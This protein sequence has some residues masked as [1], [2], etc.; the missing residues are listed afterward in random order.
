MGNTGGG[1]LTHM[2]TATIIVAPINDTPTVDLDANDSSGATGNDYAITFTEGAGPIGIAD[3][4]VD[5]LD[6]DST[7]FAYVKLGIS[8]LLNGNAETLVLDGNTFALTTAVVGQ[9]TTGGNYHVVLATGAGTATVTITKQGGGT[10]TEVETE[11]LIK[12]IQYQHTDTNVPTDGD[13]LIDVYVNDGAADSATARTTINVNPVNDPP[14]AVGDGFT[15]SEGSTN[16]LNLFNNDSDPDDGLDLTSI[17]IVSGPAS[18][19]VGNP[20][21]D[22]TVD[23][24]HNG[25]ETLS[26]SFTYTIRDLSGLYLEYCHGGFDRSHRSTMRP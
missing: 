23:Y 21:N 3:S 16:R 6:P 22:G 8:G 5:L 4:D 20:N 26:D 25:S 11:T 24:T 9:D 18:N 1:S 2:D 15:V 7:T 10:F 14:L 13:R 12:A 19:I 17:T